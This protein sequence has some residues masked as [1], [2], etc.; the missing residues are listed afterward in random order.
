MTRILIILGTHRSGSNFVADVL[1]Q[2]D[3]LILGEVFDAFFLKNQRGHLIKGMSI[4]DLLPNSG[5]PSLFALRYKNPPLFLF[6]LLRSLNRVTAKKYVGFRLFYNQLNASRRVYWT[7][8][9][10][11]YLPFVRFVHL[12]R[13]NLLHSF[14]SLEK[15]K[16][17][18]SFGSL[19]KEDKKR[20]EIT[21]DIAQYEKYRDRI[22]REIKKYDEWMGKG[23]VKII[24]EDLLSDED[25]WNSLGNELGIIGLSNKSTLN[26]QSREPFN[27]ISNLKE[28]ESFLE[29]ENDRLFLVK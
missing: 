11:R 5:I 6:R 4:Y 20:T 24:Y 21:F 8:S 7:I 1:N 22:A 2:R 15:A 17:S 10:L 23:D 27:G 26:K 28:V 18:R 14:I 9:I 19:G 3:C 25:Q 13:R 16:V 12:R 29:K